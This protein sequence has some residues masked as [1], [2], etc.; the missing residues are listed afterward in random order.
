MLTFKQ[1]KKLN[2][3]DEFQDSL[4]VHH[5]SERVFMRTMAK[6]FNDSTGQ[7]DNRITKISSKTPITIFFGNSKIT[8]IKSVEYI[9]KSQKIN[10]AFEEIDDSIKAYPKADIMITKHDGSKVPISL[11]SSDGKWGKAR[12]YVMGLY[13][14]LKSQDPTFSKKIYEVPD[15]IAENAIFGNDILPNGFVFKENFDM[16]FSNFKKL[17]DKNYKISGTVITK[18]DDIPEKDAPR[19]EISNSAP[20]YDILQKNKV[21]N[22]NIPHEREQQ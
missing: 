19:I 10:E 1:H 17:D 16:E 2:E 9:G 21:N 12:S 4:Q 20:I 15:K 14:K 3:I 8:N 18:L 7:K 11:K 13:K 5:K 6:I 22:S